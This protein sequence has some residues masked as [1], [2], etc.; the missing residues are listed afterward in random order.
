MVQRETVKAKPKFP[1]RSVHKTGRETIETLDTGIYI[2]RRTTTNYPETFNKA[3]AESEPENPLQTLARAKVSVQK[4]LKQPNLPDYMREDS[5]F[6]LV[7]IDEARDFIRLRNTEYAAAYCLL[8]GALYEQLRIQ[9]VEPFFAPKRTQQQGAQKPRGL[10]KPWCAVREFL[11]A[12]PGASPLQVY[13]K[14][15]FPA[16]GSANLFNFRTELYRKRAKKKLV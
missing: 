2:R 7:M 13:R 9:A 3:L 4:G 16:G 1:V 12:N 6:L 15:Y 8:V 10:W 14:A 5:R 11:A